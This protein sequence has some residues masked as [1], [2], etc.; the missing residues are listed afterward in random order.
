LRHFT[1]I[2]KHKAGTW[3]PPVRNG[4]HI[5]SAAA[6]GNR[7]MRPARRVASRKALEAQGV[8]FL[9]AGQVAA[10]AGVA[11]VVKV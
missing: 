4:L 3:P 6:F 2:K 10:G 8:K 5:Y 7:S 1:T 9:G 11:V